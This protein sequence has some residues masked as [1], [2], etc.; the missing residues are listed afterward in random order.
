[1][2]TARRNL[3]RITL[4]D[5][6]ITANN[7]NEFKILDSLRANLRRVILSLLRECDDALKK[8]VEEKHITSTPVDENTNTDE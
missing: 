2:E 5:D 4:M 8:I 1:M 6:E 3:L 7:R